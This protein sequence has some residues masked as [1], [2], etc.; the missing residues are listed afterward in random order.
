MIRR[1]PR[2]AEGARMARR[3]RLSSLVVLLSLVPLLAA[4]ASDAP[5]DTN[6]P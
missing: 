2:P 5:Q 1:S 4:C 3:R 6:E